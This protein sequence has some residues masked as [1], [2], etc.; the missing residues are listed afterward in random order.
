VRIEAKF[1]AMIANQLQATATAHAAVGAAAAPH[2]EPAERALSARTRERLARISHERSWKDGDVL[3]HGGEVA[4]WIIGREQGRLRVARI[5]PSGAED[6]RKG[7][8]PG[9]TLGLVSVV[10]QRPFPF[11]VT[12]AGPCV[13]RL[14]D[15][16]KVLALM[17]EDGEVALDLA[18]SLALWA[19]ELEELTLEDR[20]ENLY[21]RIQAVLLRLYALGAARPVSDGVSLRVSQYDLACMVG[22]SRQY[23]NLQLRRMQ[24]MGEVRLGYRSIILLHPPGA[25]GEAKAGD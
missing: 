11:S 15:A 22:S 2:A 25:A 20:D 8:R 12:A 1:L 23:V 13:T 17:R 10:A 7:V 16:Q 18:R 4:R 6:L 21:E 24:E 5:R 9:G 19:A 3:L 14:Y